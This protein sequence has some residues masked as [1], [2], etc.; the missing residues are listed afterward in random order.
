MNDT[1]A[2]WRQ[3]PRKK[4]NSTKHEADIQRIDTDT[5]KV[6]SHNHI[7][8]GD[9][10]SNKM[11]RN[12]VKGIT[13]DEYF[14]AKSQIEL[15]LDIDPI[16]E[17]EEDL[18]K[19]CDEEF[20]VEDSGHNRHNKNVQTPEF[21]QPPLNRDK[22]PKKKNNPSKPAPRGTKLKTEVECQPVSKGKVKSKSIHKKHLATSTN[23]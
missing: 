21:H 6:E 2:L 23:E 19:Y 14:R 22:A 3:I 4:N 1:Y 18:K 7:P 10:L 13:L 12:D 20:E 9:R 11:K 17:E 16:N 15:G 5:L 8:C